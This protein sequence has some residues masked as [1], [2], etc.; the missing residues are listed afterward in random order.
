MY[1]DNKKTIK[2]VMR[3]LPVDTPTDD[4]ET[5]L[6]EMK[7]P[8]ESVRQLRRKVENDDTGAKEWKMIPLWVIF[9]MH[10]K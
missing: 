2:V 8:I 5:Q 3:G 6:L 10:L 1:Q 7:Y 9:I 4:I